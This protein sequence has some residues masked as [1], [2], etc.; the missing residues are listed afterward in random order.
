[1]LIWLILTLLEVMN[2]WGNLIGKD[3][4]N[5]CDFTAIPQDEFIVN[6]N[7]I[8]NLDYAEEQ[9]INKKIYNLKN[10]KTKL[11]INCVFYSLWIYYSP[12]NKRRGF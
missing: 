8:Q 2:L 1:M 4:N 3:V 11:F 6:L 12:D 5:K 10:E 9:R 7:L